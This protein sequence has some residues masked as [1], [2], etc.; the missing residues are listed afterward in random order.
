MNTEKK[1][2]AWYQSTFEEVHA[3]EHLL[4]KVEAMANKEQ[5]ETRKKRLR[6]GYAAAAAVALLVFSNVISYAASGSPWILTV[7]LPDGE[8]QQMEVEPDY[9]NGTSSYIYEYTGEVDEDSP[10]SVSMESTETGLSSDDAKDVIYSTLETKNGRT[11][12]VI[13]NQYRVDI[14]EDFKDGSCKGSVKEDGQYWCYEV[15]GTPEDYDI[16]VEIVDVTIK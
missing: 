15:T 1:N 9:D 11:W 5:R 14:T 16:Q 4:R 3:S 12:L 10:I 2:Q 8:V 7:T 6:T 13:D